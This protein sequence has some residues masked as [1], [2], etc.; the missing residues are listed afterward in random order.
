[1]S[2]KQMADNLGVSL[3]AIYTSVKNLKMTR[4]ELELEREHK[5][6]ARPKAV[7]SNAS[8]KYLSNNY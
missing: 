2:H 3:S 7:Y 4:K 8:F 6:K 5:K 1:M